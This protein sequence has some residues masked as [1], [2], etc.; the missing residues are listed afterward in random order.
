MKHI[1]L[2]VFLA[3]SSMSWSQT[4]NQFDSQGKR[5]GQWKKNFEG[6][7]VVRYEGTFSHGKEVG[8]FKFYK[9]IKGKAVL[10]AT[11]EF[12][13]NDDTAK[14]T[15]LASTGSVISEGVMQSKTYIGP[16]KYYHNNSKQLMTMETYDIKGLLQGERLVYYPNGQIA[17]K[18]LYKDNKLD[19]KA[20]WYSE[21]GVVIKIYNYNMGILHGEAKFYDKA[22]TIVAEGIYRDDKKHGIWKYYEEGKLTEEKD[23]TVRSKNPYKKKK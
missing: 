19:D 21:E 1:L 10:T 9:N 23:F 16:W 18:T 6:T 8:V 14:V 5:D 4:F 22:G 15:F 2:I 13:K 20:L 17:E 12:N 11:R 3:I 7:N